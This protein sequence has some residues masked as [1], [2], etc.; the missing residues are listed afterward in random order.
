MTSEDKSA[1]LIIEPRHK[2]L[3]EA[4]TTAGTPGFGICLTYGAS[5]WCATGRMFC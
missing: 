1:A 2:I 5:H 3:I 4:E